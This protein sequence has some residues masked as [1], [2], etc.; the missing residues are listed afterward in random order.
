MGDLIDVS[1]GLTVDELVITYN[2]PVEH[3]RMTLLV[4]PPESKVQQPDDDE[5]IRTIEL[6]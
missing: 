2:L 1:E 4:G 5:P 3:I 6:D